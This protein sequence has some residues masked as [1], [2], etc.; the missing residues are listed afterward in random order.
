MRSV[1]IAAIIC[2]M[3][4]PVLAAA[5]QKDEE[6]EIRNLNLHVS[7][8]MFS[9]VTT[10]E[11]EFYNPNAKVLDGSFQFSLLAHQVVTGFSLDINGLMRQ[12]VITTKQN[13]RIA[14]ENTIRRRIDPGLLE[15]TGNNNYR[16][17]IYPM[18]AN[19]TRKITITISE[20][21][22]I[23]QNALVYQFPMDISYAIKS[24]R[25]KV[26]ASSAFRPE[27][28][29]GEQGEN[30]F[31]NSG[32]NKYSLQGGKKNIRLKNTLSFSIPIPE[33]KMV[34]SSYVTGD[35]VSRFALHVK[36][37]LGNYPV[38]NFK[39][40]VVFWDV[41]SSAA[42]RQNSYGKFFPN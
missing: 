24:Y 31:Q 21:L 26:D 33:K 35:S 8:D 23:K 20:Q 30:V 5:Q 3:L 32:E 29:N 9:A 41:S 16:V 40:I 36:P 28:G 1:I 2:S 38:P 12:G 22:Q 39:S 7:A 17:R 4:T 11:I 42:K 6:I 10:M 14:Y 27:F 34:I 37:M 25:W 13:G 18:P 19:G 15:M